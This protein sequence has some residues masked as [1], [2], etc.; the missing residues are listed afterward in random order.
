MIQH[1]LIMCHRKA[2]CVCARHRS[3]EREAVDKGV[4]V[5][6]CR[7]VR[8]GADLAAERELR[9]RCWVGCT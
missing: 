9:R 7:R 1:M 5:E 2:G 8:V 3:F 6:D 4:L